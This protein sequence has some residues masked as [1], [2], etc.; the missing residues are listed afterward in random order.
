MKNTK[1]GV[2]KSPVLILAVLGLLVGAGAT[3]AIAAGLVPNLDTGVSGTVTANVTD[4][5]LM[6]LSSTDTTFKGFT[7]QGGDTVKFSENIAIQ[8]PGYTNVTVAVLVNRV[9][10]PANALIVSM[11]GLGAYVKVGLTLGALTTPST[12]NVTAI[13]NGE[14]LVTNGVQANGG[15]SSAL[16]N[17]WNFAITEGQAPLA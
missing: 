5:P 4:H 6:S 10:D 7:S 3:G 12:A 1:T 17:Q 2:K 11:D 15:Y 9:V 14:W 16:D 8:A 13:G